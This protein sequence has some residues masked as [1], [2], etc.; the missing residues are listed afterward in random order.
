MAQSAKRREHSEKLQCQGPYI[1][2][3]C[4]MRYAILPGPKDQVFDVQ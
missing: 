2:T 3:L 4:A 1:Y